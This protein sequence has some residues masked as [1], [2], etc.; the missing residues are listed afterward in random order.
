MNAPERNAAN[1]ARLSMRAALL[2]AKEQRL[3]AA[4]ITLGSVRED[5]RAGRLANDQLR[6]DLEARRHT[7]DAR[8]AELDALAGSLELQSGALYDDREAFKLI[9]Q[10][11]N[12]DLDAKRARLAAIADQIKERRPEIAETVNAAL[13]SRSSLAP[14]VEP[15]ECLAEARRQL[16]VYAFERNRL[17]DQVRELKAERESLNARLEENAMRAAARAEK[18][19][20]IAMPAGLVPMPSPF[21]NVPRRLES[22]HNT[23][24]RDYPLEWQRATS[25]PARRA[26]PHLETIGDLLTSS[27]G[28]QE[29]C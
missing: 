25:A 22:A 17:I 1:A 8:A 11:Q 13:A 9:Q 12:A 28:L 15:N 26:P 19:R 21:D 6:L 4:Q 2:L 18:T 20:K 23:P 29:L 16:Q 27:R 5:L 14:A 3:E 10:E 7:L 24:T